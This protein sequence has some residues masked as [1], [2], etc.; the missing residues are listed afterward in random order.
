MCGIVA[1]DS[2]RRHAAVVGGPFVAR[3]TPVVAQSVVR[4]RAVLEISIIKQ[5]HKC[6]VAAGLA[7]RGMILFEQ[8]NALRDII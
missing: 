7:G 1:A 5:I 3:R 8:P 4:R 2:R 6:L